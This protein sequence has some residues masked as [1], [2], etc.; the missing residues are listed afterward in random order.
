MRDVHPG[1][2]CT[3]SDSEP[4]LFDKGSNLQRP[5][6][7]LCAARSCRKTGNGGSYQR[8]GENGAKNINTECESFKSISNGC[9]A[10]DI[11]I[12]INLFIFIH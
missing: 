7:E 10:R 12:Y 5:G 9:R 2:S 4:D 3:S 1:T 6:D 8:T 11:N